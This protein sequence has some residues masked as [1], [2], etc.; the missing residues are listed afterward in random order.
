MAIE[1]SESLQHAAVMPIEKILDGF[2]S[3]PANGFPQP[4]LDIP[5][6]GVEERAPDV[7]GNEPLTEFDALELRALY[8]ESVTAKLWKVAMKA[9]DWV[10]PITVL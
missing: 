5:V 8:S 6:Q 2:P 3:K 4:E 1:T 7:D 10:S 9:S